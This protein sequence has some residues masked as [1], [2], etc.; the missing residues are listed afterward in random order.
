MTVVGLVLWAG[1]GAVLGLT[2]NSKSFAQGWSEAATEESSTEEQKPATGDRSDRRLLVAG[3]VSAVVA[4][5]VSMVAIVGETVIGLLF[6]LPVA[7]I[8]A[9]AVLL[10]MSAMQLAAE[11]ALDQDDD[12]MPF[13][14]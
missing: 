12:Q 7:A 1:I 3:T 9:G 11:N 13:D 10:V 5:L 4:G 14:Q 6:S 8:G 2:V